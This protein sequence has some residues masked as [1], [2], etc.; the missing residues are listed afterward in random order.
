MKKILMII[1]QKNFQEVECFEPK[2]ILE[3]KGIEVV[4]AAPKKELAIGSLGG[5]IMP[6][7]GFD[8][9]KIKDYDGVA[10]IGGPGSHDFYDND[11]LVNLILEFDYEKKMIAAICFSPSVLAKAGVLTNKKATVHPNYKDNLLKEGV[12]YTEA[13][14]EVDGRFITADGPS[15]ATDFGS[16]LA[17]YLLA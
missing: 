14:V 16:A 4:V 15:S 11:F 5:S 6:D 8:E 3:A 10:I 1:A 13:P 7:I 2:K 17:E 9:I 12:V